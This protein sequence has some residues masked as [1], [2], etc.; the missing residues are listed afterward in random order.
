MIVFFAA[1][2]SHAQEAATVRVDAVKIEPLVRTVPVTGRLVARRAGTIAARIDGPL[3]SILVEIGDRVD[4]HQAVALLDNTLLTAQQSLTVARLAEAQ[5]TLETRRAELG[6]A[7][8]EAKRLKRLK[9]T[10]ATTKAAYDDAVQGEVIAEAKAKEAQA[11]LTSA[12]ANRAIA[13][14]NLKNT[15]IQAPYDGVITQRLV[16]A[17]AYVKVGDDVLRIIAD[18]SL[19]VE[20]DVPFERLAGLIPGTELIIEL[21]DGTSHTVRVRTVIPQENNLTRTRAV[22]FVPAFKETLTP[23]AANQSATVHIPTAA[24]RDVLSVHKDAVIKRG[25]QS[26]VYVVTN[27]AAELRSVVLGEA[28]SDRFEVLNGLQ[29][30]DLA[31]VRGNERLRP[32]QEVSLD[33]SS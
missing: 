20:A 33:T 1:E 4:E 7:R 10:A 18:Q 17:G 11:A 14:I 13:D 5:A 32:G 16:E 12:V 3:K 25:D 6:L 27:D 23:L 30:G 29:E 15:T 26:I 2:L 19:E 8:L 24:P 9:D 31:V 28:V 21:D 22:R